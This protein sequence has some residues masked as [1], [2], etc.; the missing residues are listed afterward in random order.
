MLVLNKLGFKD[1]TAQISLRDKENKAGVCGSDEVWEKAEAA[2]IDAAKEVNME[3]ITAYGE[4]V[5]NSKA[6]FYGEGCFR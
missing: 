1:Y 5:Y 4:A 6:R 2:I 3:T